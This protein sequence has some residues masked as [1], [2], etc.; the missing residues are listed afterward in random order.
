MSSTSVL[1]PLLLATEH[2]EQDLGAEQVAFALAASMAQP[3]AVVMPLASNPEYEAVAPQLAARAEADIARRREALGAAA[4]AAGVT[5]AV[6]VRR[7]SELYA[8][9]VAAARE[10]HSALL[11]VRRRGQ[12]GLLANLLIGE[13]VSKVLAHAPCSVLVVPR[14][15]GPAQRGLLVGVDPQQL[16]LRPVAHAAAVAAALGLPLHLVCVVPREGERAR[17]DE[18]LSSAHAGLAV[19]PASAEVRIGAAHAQIIAAAQARDADL[20]AV[21]RHGGHALGRAWIGGVAQKVIGLAGCAVLVLVDA[22][23]TGQSAG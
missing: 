21:A 13:M 14:E 23:A 4:L 9:I 2:G 15:A 1:Q 22:A 7:G 18:A 11:V 12:R 5:V 3:L 16:E 17:A 6:Q 19:A 10:H 8:E 20:I